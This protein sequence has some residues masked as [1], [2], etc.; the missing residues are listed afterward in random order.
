[1]T[2][3][4][5]LTVMGAVAATWLAAGLLADAL[6]DVGTARVLLRR[7]RLLTAL[8]GLGAALLV[9]VP[10]VAAAT[11]GPSA[12]PAAAL[13]P[14]VPA[15]VVL[16]VTVRHLAWLRR[17]AAAFATAP[18]TPSSPVLRA[19]AAHPLVATPLQVT[20]LAALAGLPIAAGVVR[21][22]GSGVAGIAICVVGVAVIAIGARHALR[23]SRLAEGAVR[24]RAMFRST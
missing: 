6:P 16:A 22:P 7:T 3:P 2:T 12:L 17:G 4:A 8:V 18:L 15:L 23:H 21:L 11:P 24:V 5:D 13:L 9:A 10:F 1:V 20:G 19:A 14:A